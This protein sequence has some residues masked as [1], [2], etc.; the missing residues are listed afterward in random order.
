MFKKIFVSICSIVTIVLCTLGIVGCNTQE[1]VSNDDKNV[2]QNDFEFTFDEEAP[3]EALIGSELPTYIRLSSGAVTASINGVTKTLI[4]TVYPED[5]TNVEVDWTI[6]WNTN[7]AHISEDISNYLLL[8]VAEDGSREASVTCIK[9]FEGSS[10]TITVT[11]R[12]GGYKAHCTATYLG[13]PKN[14]GIDINGNTYGA[15]ADV[16]VSTGTYNGSLIMYNDLGSSVDGSNA[17]GSQYGNYEVSALYVDAKYYVTIEFVLN[18]VVKLSEDVLI[19][20]SNSSHSQ[21][22]Q[23]TYDSSQESLNLT[24]DSST[25]ANASISG[26][27]IS[28]N[29]VKTQGSYLYGGSSTRTGWR[30]KYKGAYYDPRGNGEAYPCVVRV[31]YKE[32]MSGITGL[33]NYVLASTASSVSLDNE[34]IEF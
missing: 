31:E 33:V 16:S 4:A 21:T 17:I 13:V 11:T 23:R 1:S 26:N 6:E 2:I 29:I 28:T 22:I 25:F 9:G 10:A 24:V 8:S 3:E 14:L 20:I 19:D 12:D 15:Y 27:V 5:A 18:G 32:T 7:S 34:A 30:V